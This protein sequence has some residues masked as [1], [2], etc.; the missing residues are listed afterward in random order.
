[1]AAPPVCR[2]VKTVRSSR[3]R[4]VLAYADASQ[5]AR[6]GAAMRI[7]VHPSVA[8][9]VDLKSCAKA[10]STVRKPS[11]QISKDSTSAFGPASTPA[12][13]SYAMTTSAGSPSTS[14]PTSSDLLPIARFGSPAPS[15]A[16]SPARAT[17]YPTEA[18]TSS[19]G[20]LT[21]GHSRPSTDVEPISIP[22]SRCE[23]PKDALI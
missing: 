5:A 3:H 10:Q 14:Q 7:V 2:R 13:A 8:S 23:C 18:N 15:R 17:S 21:H 6:V 20:Y 11:Q 12:K 4:L 22:G 19:R 1:M 9:E 16:S